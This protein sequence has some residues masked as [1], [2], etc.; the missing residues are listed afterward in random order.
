M[1]S[2]AILPRPIVVVL[3]SGLKPAG[4]VHHDR[5]TDNI[6]DVLLYR[7][8]FFRC[9]IDSFVFQHAENRMAF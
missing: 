8:V 7:S 6:L 9:A 2:S 5:L 4:T 3:C 1:K